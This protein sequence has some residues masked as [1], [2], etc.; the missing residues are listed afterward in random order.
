MVVLLA[1]I[2]F[3][4]M[5]RWFEHKQ[6]YIPM[7][8]HSYSGDVLGRP[9]EDVYFETEDGVRLNAWYFPAPEK[10]G[11]SNSVVLICHGN[12]GNI[13]HRLDLYELLHGLGL[14]VFAFDYRGYGRSQGTPSEEGTY[15]DTRA[16]HRWLTSKG[17]ASTNII[18]LGESLGGAMAAELAMTEP[19]RGIILQ[20]TF[21]SIP[22][23]G[24]ELF[25]FLPVKLISTIRYDTVAKLPRVQVPVL[26]IHSRDDSIIGYH[27]A[28]KNFAAANEPKMLWEI[29]GD[30]NDSVLD[31]G[32][33]YQE[34]IET[35]L[36]MIAAQRSVEN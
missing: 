33:R 21:T 17:Y 29:S 3:W 20:S 8:A 12:A 10:S 27:H 4:T 35:F 16:A 36:S 2:L 25:P 18:A 30:H 28:E 5:I 9:W 26:I 19:L 6:I 14:N 24:A 13:S 31:G 34:G 7:T 15:L 1:P 32:G 23:V 22:D 11:Q